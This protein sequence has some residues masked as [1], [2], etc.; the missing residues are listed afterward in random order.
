MT[1]R[2][3]T[4]RGDT[5]EDR[6]GSMTAMK[7]AYL[8]MERMQRRIDEHERARTEPIAIVGVG[9]RFPGGVTDPDSY[10][11]LLASGTDTIG[12]IPAD[13]WDVEAF[14]D[15]QPRT[16]GKHSTRWG[17]FLDHIDRFDHE[18]FGISRRE[19]VSM[20]PQQRLVLEVAWAALEDAGQAPDALAGSRTGVFLGI[21]S[22]DYAGLLFR[23][24]QDITA[25][26]STGVAHSIASGRLSYLLDL[27]GPSV[28]VD[29]ACSSSLVAVHQACQNLRLG[30]CD[31]AMAGGVN[32]VV[33]PDAA[34]SFSQFPEMLAD[35]GRCKTFDAAANGFVRSEGCGVVVL[36]RLSDARRD[37]DRVLAVIRGSAVN[38]D[39]RSSGLTAPSG[40]AQREV[41]RRALAAAG[42]GP[43]RVGYIE[44]HGAGTKLGDPIEVSALAEV[45]GRPEGA[46]LHLGAV[47]TN[48]G[49]LEA[50]AGI[51]GLI[52]AALCLDRGQIPPNL[53][54]AELNPHISFEGTTFAVPTALTPWPS[55]GARRLAGVSSFGFS[56][57]NAHLI[58][59]Q[60]PDPRVA[61]PDDAPD[62][63]PENG[64]EDGRPLTVLALSARSGG[65][66]LKL[67]RRYQDRLAKAGPAGA[68][69]LCFSANT[70]RSHFPHRLAAVG[71]TPGELAERLADFVRD[72]PGEGLLLGRSGGAAP[73]GPGSTAEPVFLFTGQGP[74]RAGMARRLY[75]TQPFFRRTLD[76][77]DE[78]L[79]GV[80]P[81]PL[82][83]A[84]YP[85]SAADGEL[86]NT[87]EFAQPGLFAVEYALAGLWRS[88]GVEPA[89][90]IGHSLGEYAAACFAGAL[91][92]ED[93]LRL[94]AERGRLLQRL[95]ESGAM[96]AIAAP[97]DE[98]A[99]ELARHDE[100]LVAVAAVNGPANTTVSGVR[101]VVDEVC[102]AF[103]ARGA[104]VRR[105]RIST[106]SHSPLVEPVLEPLRV[107]LEKVPFGA[108]A[109]PLLSNLTGGL[110]PWDRPLDTDYWLRHARQPVLFA[111]GVRALYELGHRTFLEVGPAPTLLGLVGEVLT[112]DD[113]LMLPSLRPKYDDW[114]VLL[115]SL[116]RLYAEGAEV[117]WAGFDREY[118]RTRM[119]LPHY[120]FAATRCW[121]EPS[122]DGS[123]AAPARRPSP[124]AERPERVRRTERV[125]RAERTEPASRPAP[126]VTAPARR[127][128]GAPG[129]AAASALPTAEELLSAPAEQ[130]VEALVA[131]L[132]ASVRTAL[133]SRGAAVDADAPL[134]ALGLDSLMAVEL[135]NE[136]QG[137]LG[138][139]VTVA[140]FLKGATVRSL[141]GQ[142]VEGLTAAGPGGATVGEAAPIR[143]AARSTDLA[144]DRTPDR[145]PDPTA[146]LLALLEQVTEGSERVD[147]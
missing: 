107:A 38:Q 46:P 58:V 76:Q 95:A 33:A 51:A 134:S 13:R 99:A 115:G 122:G 25:H 104:E 128:P 85:A 61:G 31:L 109:V 28:S 91:P 112:G 116:G 47:K 34:I 22:N 1:T 137:R 127:L 57:T 140:E 126:P 117:D 67:A 62:T 93:G 42:V 130:R 102:A 74:Q 81:A 14:Y 144:P 78:I 136:I 105:L 63:R 87:M 124:R 29:T 37:G 2:E 84:V 9:C 106:S 6:T 143:R 53:H 54:F 129:R 77:C 133:G 11:E 88:W 55:D 32:A 10:W 7:R 20:D 18:F 15:E 65:A 30:E 48:L 56:G 121:H 120:P 39:G 80:L 64:P 142:V 90:V 97:A 113:V 125:P 23:E 94:V 59:E 40:A 44:T 147:D 24:P 27:R 16:P 141:A 71:A 43:D 70:G 135:R 96:A 103:A 79:R 114:E 83:S 69:D 145:T 68:A 82:L 86:I 108:P 60:A 146:E 21:C 17:G 75:E 26:A 19:A 138:V 123:A 41:F 89:A 35:D 72:D 118:R 4:T 98:V 5:P 111:D 73:A 36:K 49:H 12:E 66:L 100:A 110:W 50:A 3:H 131:G 52:K 119:P 101:E 8:T 45:Y 139:K 132:T 92:L